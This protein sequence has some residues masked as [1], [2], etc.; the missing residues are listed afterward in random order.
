MNHS[1]E[2]K[3]HPSRLPALHPWEVR[4]GS[5]YDAGYSACLK[6]FDRCRSRFWINSDRL[7]RWC[8]YVSERCA[9]RAVEHAYGR[10]D[11]KLE[12]DFTVTLTKKTAQIL[13]DKNTVFFLCF[14]GVHLR[15]EHACCRF[16][17]QACAL[18]D[19]TPVIHLESCLAK[20]S[21][22]V[23]VLWLNI[24]NLPIYTVSCHIMQSPSV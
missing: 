22:K 11:W 16:G 8:K 10:K 14:L 4:L 23:K 5:W 1:T 17:E 6:M 21:E 15:L 13:T 19:K 18:V 2:V 7:G 20:T 9:A 24:P 3:E 12:T